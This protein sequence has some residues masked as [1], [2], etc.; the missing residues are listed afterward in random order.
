MTNAKT[1]IV[2]L[3]V[4]SNGIALASLDAHKAADHERAMVAAALTG[5][6]FSTAKAGQYATRYAAAKAAIMAGR[7][8]AAL[9]A[10][11]DNR[12]DATLI[13]HGF[14]VLKMANHGAKPKAGQSVR[15]ENDQAAY[16]SA[17]VIAG[18]VMAAAGV[19]SPNEAKAANAAKGAATKAKNAG[20]AKPAT[21]AADAK[22]AKPA[23]ERHKNPVDLVRYMA[24]QRAAMASTLQRSCRAVNGNMPFADDLAAL[25]VAFKTGLAEIEAKLA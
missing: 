10:K 12:P 5:I 17:G 25:L 4:N 8:A 9:R 3:P 15:T 6:R 21:N 1:K 20:K 11:G 18:R 16:K 19:K 22:P 7:I 2:A 24:N 14:A 23:I 13:A